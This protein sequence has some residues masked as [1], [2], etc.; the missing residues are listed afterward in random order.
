MSAGVMKYAFFSRLQHSTTP[1]GSHAAALPI[2]S[3]KYLMRK[4]RR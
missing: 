2:S 4:R 3:R 1:F